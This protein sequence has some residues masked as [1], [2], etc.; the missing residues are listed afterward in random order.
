[1]TKATPVF[2]RAKFSTNKIKHGF[3]N[4]LTA[5]FKENDHNNLPNPKLLMKE[6]EK[7]NKSFKRSRNE[8]DSSSGPGKKLPSSPQCHQKGDHDS[9]VRLDSPP[10]L[11]QRL[12]LKFQ[13]T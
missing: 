7:Y 11:A 9:S 13:N 12:K 6:T 8:E 2:E 1:M 4:N 5:K 3:Q 10:P